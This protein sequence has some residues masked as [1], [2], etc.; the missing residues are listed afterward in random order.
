M[1]AAV[2]SQ[3]GGIEALK[4]KGVEVRTVCT[5]TREGERVDVQELVKEEVM[6]EG[7]KGRS[8][9]AVCCGPGALVDGVRKSVVGAVRKKG[10]DVDLVED[11]FC[12]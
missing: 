5:G 11:A 12:W 10:V 9:C 4:I 2:R 6:S 8:V 7:A 1:I 3:I